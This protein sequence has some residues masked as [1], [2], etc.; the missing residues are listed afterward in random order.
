MDRVSSVSHV[1]AGSTALTDCFIRGISDI[2]YMKDLLGRYVLTNEANARFLG[3]TIEEIIGLDDFALFPA[4]QARQIAEQDRAVYSSGGSLTFEDEFSRGE[5]VIVLESVKTVCRDSAGEVIG[6]V[7]ISRDIGERKRLEVMLRQR[8]SELAETQ[9]LAERD[10]QLATQR[11]QNVLD[12]ITDG[13]CVLDRDLRYVY[14]NENGAR[15]VGLRSSD[16]VGTRVGDTFAEN[17]TNQI[18][19]AY[20]QSLDTGEPVHVEEFTVAPLNKWFESNC[21]PSAD[22]LTVYFR[23][24]TDR[25]R[26]EAALR[27]SEKLAATGRLAASIAHEINNP[28]AAVTNSLYLA[29]QD[30]TLAP[31]TRNYL[32]LADQEL[33]RVSQITTQTLRFHRQSRSAVRAELSE[34]MKSVLPLFAPRWV[35]RQ[36]Q[37]ESRLE[38]DTGILCFADEI[39]QVFSNLLSNALDA[40]PDGGRLA[41]KIRKASHGGEA[42]VRVTVADTGCGI[43]AAAKSRI[44]EAFFSTKDATGIGLGLWV[45]EGIV[46]KH[47]GKI[48]VRSSTDEARHGTVFSLF[49]PENGLRVEAQ[50]SATA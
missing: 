18:Y 3:K 26:T 19:R 12:S 9:R 46:R 42:G 20:R 23:D 30:A 6:L 43:P 25:K 16:I 32:E 22:G 40:T 28:L 8:E 35:A 48:S 44:F 50:P 10:S 47:A 37:V 49:F 27:R 24:I 45:S 1:V 7:G 5:Q 15:M 14:F 21:Y 17:K 34:I 29:L 41:L 39:R 13:L 38:A 11:L 2:A 33:T 31:A 4:E 36:I